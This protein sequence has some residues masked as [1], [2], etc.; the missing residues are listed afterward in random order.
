MWR[1]FHTR[2]LG[3][4][5]A[6]T[7]RIDGC[8]IQLL[9]DDESVAA[10]TTSSA[11]SSTDQNSPDDES[12]SNSDTPMDIDDEPQSIERMISQVVNVSSAAGAY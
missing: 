2:W 6:S 4:G 7:P 12:V 3:G 8:I 1:R 11:S 9:E 5:W 10:A